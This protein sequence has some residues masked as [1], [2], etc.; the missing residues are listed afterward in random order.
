MTMKVYEAIADVTRALS[1]EGISKDRKNESQGY[2]FRGI[3]DVYNALAPLLAASKLCILP[4]VLSREV[5]ER[6]SNVLRNV[7]L[8]PLRAEEPS[9]PAA[10]PRPRPRE[11]AACQAAST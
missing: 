11:G 6:A 10:S 5:V 9:R 3:D 1:R 4:N 7:H 8:L 2:R